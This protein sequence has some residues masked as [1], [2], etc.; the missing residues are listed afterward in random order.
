MSCVLLCFK[1][2]Q[3][4]FIYFFFKKNTKSSASK[5]FNLGGWNNVTKSP[6]QG[7]N[8][9]S[10][11]CGQNKQPYDH[12][13]NAITCAQQC[14]THQIRLLVEKV[15]ILRYNI[16]SIEIRGGWNY[17]MLIHQKSTFPGHFDNYVKIFRQNFSLFLPGGTGIQ[18]LF[19]PLIGSAVARS[20][21]MSCTFPTMSQNG[22]K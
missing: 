16:D 4:Y 15:S 13:S 21:L 8:I 19:L 12:E 10:L 9:K 22:K 11:I 6:A 14:F 1:K 5:F 20:H 18:W 7:L 17:I 3:T 2:A